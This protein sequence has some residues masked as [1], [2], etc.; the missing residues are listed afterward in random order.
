LKK[1]ISKV[2]WVWRSFFYISQLLFAS[3]KKL[4]TSPQGLNPPN[5]AFLMSPRRGIKEKL[6]STQKVYGSK[7]FQPF[8]PSAVFGDESTSVKKEFLDGCACVAVSCE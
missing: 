6:S 4:A 5:E 8:E 2:P 7:T 3:T 1:Y